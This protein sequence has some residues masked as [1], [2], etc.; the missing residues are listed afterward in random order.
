MRVGVVADGWKDGAR[1]IEEIDRVVPAE[2]VAC[3]EH[4]LGGLEDPVEDQ[5][6]A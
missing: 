2:L 6:A 1:A 4:G 5:P 3:E